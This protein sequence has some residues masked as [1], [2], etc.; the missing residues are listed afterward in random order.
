MIRT[1]FY[2]LLVLVIALPL[3]IAAYV[4]LAPI[5]AGQ[6]Q[7][8]PLSVPGRSSPNW[9]LALPEGI[10]GAVPA[11]HV[12]PELAAA[13]HRA[14][15]ALL[16]PIIEGELGGVLLARETLPDGAERASFVIRSSLMGYPDLLTVQTIE[17]QGAVFAA[18][19]SRSIYGYSDMGVN[20]ARLD[21]LV[22]RLAAAQ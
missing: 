6:A 15:I 3:A 1:L 11:T 18:L 10:S 16:L 20:S 4:R 5:D 19:Y 12:S 7:V 13:T 22:A 8:D 14:G 2:V 9:A 17:R 21:A